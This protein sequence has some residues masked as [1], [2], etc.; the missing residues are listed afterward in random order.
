MHIKSEPIYQGFILPSSDQENT[1]VKSETIE[2]KTDFKTEVKQENFRGFEACEQI[3]ID[4]I[5]DSDV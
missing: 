4:F 3:G 2:M 1:L 5:T